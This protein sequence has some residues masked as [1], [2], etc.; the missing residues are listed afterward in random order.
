MSSTATLT[1]FGMQVRSGT[2]PLLL[3]AP[4]GGRRD[5]ERHPWSEGSVRV[6]DLHTGDLTLELAERLD[7]DALINLDLDRNDVDLNRIRQVRTRAP[8]FLDLLAEHLRAL[9]QR[10]QRATVLFIHG[11]NVVNPACDVGIGVSPE[12]G[13]GTHD[14]RSRPSVDAAFLADHIRGFRAACDAC[15]IATGLGWRYPATNPGNLVQLFTGQHLRNADPRI[16]DLARGGLPINAVQLELAIPLRWPGRWRSHFIDAC[17]AAF[18][19]RPAARRPARAGVARLHDAAPEAVPEPTTRTT[20]QFHAAGAG[21][22]GVAAFENDGPS[23]SGRLLLLPE[24]GGM[25]LFTGEAREAAT[26]GC[27]SVGPL[28]LARRTDDGLTISYDGPLLAFPDR[29][30]FLDLEA[31]LSRAHTQEATIRLDVMPQRTRRIAAGDSP[32]FVGWDGFTSVDGSLSFGP[33]PDSTTAGQHSFPEG[34]IRVAGFGFVEGRSS[35]PRMGK[36]VVATLPD[37]PRGPLRLVLQ[38]GQPP[39]A[40]RY[41]EAEIERV[42]ASDVRISPDRAGALIEFTI[43]IPG[44]P[45]RRI[46]TTRERCVPIVRQGARGTVSHH[47]LSFCEFESE[48]ETAGAGWVELSL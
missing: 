27:V 7:A 38:P 47:L 44:A 4:H 36:R 1:R 46:R 41:G 28:V 19:D 8:W 17:A 45:A 31:G 35:A 21:M 2:A 43:R 39:M 16:R 13:P 9:W 48:E 20:L 14:E 6:N 26:P 40:Q 3:V 15:A 42:E 24:S 25:Y 37:H 22:A 34:S 33:V 5:P 10:H 11:W 30:P 32:P 29:T 12:S 23:T 18:D